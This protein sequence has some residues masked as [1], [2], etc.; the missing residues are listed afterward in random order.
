MADD[1]DLQSHLEDL[2]AA[3]RASREEQR[4]LVR[5]LQLLRGEI[6][7]LRAEA[8]SRP[9][10]P[11]LSEVAARESATEPTVGAAPQLT[12]RPRWTERFNAAVSRVVGRLGPIRVPI[13]ERSWLLVLVIGLLIVAVS[14]LD[15]LQPLEVLA[16]YPKQ[17]VRPDGGGNGI[18]SQIAV[19]AIDDAS[20][21]KLGPFG[22]GW[23]VHHGRVLKNLADDGARAVGLDLYF[24]QPSAEHDPAF[25]DGIRY[26]RSKRTGVVVGRDYDATRNR[27]T[28]P[29]PEVRDAVT[30]AASTY[31]QKDRVTNLVRYVSMFQKDGT[32]NEP[33]ARLVPAFSVAMALAGG[34]T[35]EQLPRYRQGILPIDFVGSSGGFSTVTYVD[36]AENRFPRGAFTG[37]YV[38]TGV[39]MSA[40]KDFFDTP[41]ESQMAGVVIH[42][43][44]LYT[45]LRGS[46]QPLDL[47]ARALVILA[48]V[49]VT[50]VI[51]ARLRRLP[52]AF[53]VAVTVAAYWAVAI[54]LGST[55]HPLR[56]D[57][58]PASAAA[59]L[60]WAAMAA[61]EKAVAFRE[62]RRTVG[63]SE[64]AFRRLEHDQA[65]RQGRLAKT[66]SVLASDVKDYS[67]FSHTHS[68]AHVRAI[69]TEYHEM[70]E[71]VIGDRGGY[72]NKFVGDAIL[73]V[74]GY[75]MDEEGTAL[76]AVTA[77][78]QMQDGLAALSAKW[79]RESQDGIEGVRIGINSGL[80]SISYLGSSKKQ[81][82]VMGDN[83]DLAARLEAAARHARCVAL[84]SPATYEE[85][86][87]SVRGRKVAVELKNRPDVTEAFAF[88]GFVDERAAE[89]RAG[90][91]DAS[92]SGES[93]QTFVGRG[94]ALARG[95]DA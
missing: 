44:A 89:G 68:P 66:V 95:D 43:N 90:A 86:K 26:A 39:F 20:V 12:P 65:F 79:K 59:A 84:L 87:G 71:R 78:K 28:P 32:G 51:C 61:R 19:V 75:P 3:L 46:A 72:V 10:P 27:L 34:M 60:V 23:R 81:L 82:D 47:R 93:A 25:L 49:A 30:V 5:E 1:G 50:G 35:I 57:V 55:Q 85:V 6:G 38:V 4:A 62:L 80:V 56:L 15:I 13:P 36:V 76:R 54:A 14:E 52:R 58:V 45:L 69:M 70:A 63:L 64:K 73:A 41:V 40:S 77:A 17:W 18:A 9:Q 74:F 88:D 92:T 94:T 67:V 21:E 37:K 22:K 8:A 53:A 7:A 16:D 29:V 2:I 91:Y 31:L 42:A 48:M 33:A 24:N 11:R 83:V